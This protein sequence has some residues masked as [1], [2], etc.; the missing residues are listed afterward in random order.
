VTSSSA[1]RV[2]R[3]HLS[4]PFVVERALVWAGLAALLHGVWELL[5]FPLLAAAAD[6][7]RVRAVAA[8]LHSILGDAFLSTAFY[9]VTAL[10]LR[11]A[12]WPRRHAKRGAALLVV[13]GTG[14]ACAMEWYRVYYLG[15]DA[16]AEVMPAIA[17][18]GVLPVL[19][20]FVIPP[21][22]VALM[23]ELDRAT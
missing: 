2:R 6:F 14:A 8:L 23:R 16:Y 17:G 9:F 20:W 12:D 15:I 11:D 3:L 13:F 7:D 5:E 18:I 4:W 10:I 1:T 21:V 19:Q 22:A